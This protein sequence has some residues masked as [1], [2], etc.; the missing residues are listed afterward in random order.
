[1]T[2][3]E[4]RAANRRRIAAGYG[5]DRPEPGLTGAEVL[6]LAKVGGGRGSS[7]GRRVAKAEVRS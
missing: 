6:A 2:P 1:M 3:A 4:R 5:E 7:P